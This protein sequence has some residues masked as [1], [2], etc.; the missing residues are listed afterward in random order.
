M[1][2]YIQCQQ[3]PI[4]K[5]TYTYIYTYTHI[6]RQ[7]RLPVTQIVYHRRFYFLGAAPDWQEITLA[8]REA[9]VSRCDGGPIEDPP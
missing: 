9:G 7:Q 4:Y 2:T 8:V 3:S 1:Y 6:R 5:H